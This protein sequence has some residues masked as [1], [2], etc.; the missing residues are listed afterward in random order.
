MNDCEQHGCE[1]HLGKFPDCLTEAIWQLSMDGGAN[2]TT[3][4][5]TDWGAHFQLFTFTSEETVTVDN[6]PTVTIPIGAYILVTYSSG[7]VYLWLYDTE[8]DA[9]EEFDAQDREYGKWID[10]QND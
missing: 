4:D 5:A 3:G 1:G 10:A 2:E 9:R 7:F 8:A 6:G